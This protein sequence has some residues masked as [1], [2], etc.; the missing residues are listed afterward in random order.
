MN[1]ARIYAAQICPVCGFKLDFTP[2][3]NG[4]QIDRDCPCCGITFGL[5]DHDEAHREA[6]Y[7]RLRKQWTENGRRWWSKKPQ[8]ED[9]NPSWQLARLE[10]LAAER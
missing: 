3:D 7:L 10:H 5:D 6:T 1:L 9:Y 8:P 4:K 2:W